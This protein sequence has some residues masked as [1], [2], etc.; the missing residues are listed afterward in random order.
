MMYHSA[1]PA[2]KVVCT[3]QPGF[4]RVGFNA[5]SGDKQ[6]TLPFT[7]LEDAETSEGRYGPVRSRCG[8]QIPEHLYDASRLR[9]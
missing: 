1:L 9:S 3:S 7:T 8:L 6:F 2:A 4:W 5:K